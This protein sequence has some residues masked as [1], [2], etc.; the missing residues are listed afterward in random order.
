MTAFRHSL[1][2]YHAL[3]QLTLLGIIIG[4]FAGL[5][6]IAF[7]W[8]IEFSLSIFLPTHNENFESLSLLSRFL[9][10][11]IGAFII[12]LC[13]H[14]I[15]KHFHHVSIGHVLERL[16]NFQGRMPFG[17][18]LV[19]FF[20]GIL[21][22][23]TGQSV[24][25]EGPAVHI[26]ASIA[27][28]LGQWFRLPSNS[29][30][31]LIGCGVAAAIAASFNTPVAGVIFAMEVILMRYSI[32]GFIPIMM[33]SSCGAL[34]TR[35]TF[36]EENWFALTSLPVNSLSELPYWIMCGVVIALFASFYIMSQM[37]FRGLTHWPLP[38]RILLAGF[39]TASIGLLFPQI[40]GLGY[41]TITLALQNHFTV[42]F[43]FGIAIAKIIATSF[44]ISMGIPGGLIGPQLLIG[45]SLGGA[46]GLMGQALLGES[47]TDTRLYVLLGMMAMMGSVLNAPL[48][49]LTA[50]M[51]LTYN[52]N[53]IF[54]GMLV[55]VISCVLTRQI[56]KSE[57]IFLQQLKM[58]GTQLK[59][60]PIQQHLNSIGIRS[61][62]TQ[63]FIICEPNIRL[64]IIKHLLANN[65]IWIIIQREEPL[66]LAA[67]DLA[68]HCKEFEEDNATDD[69]EIDLLEIPAKRYDLIAL[70]E[71][72]N[73]WEAKMLLDENPDSA[74]RVIPQTN[75]Q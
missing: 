26:G 68:N 39:V 2:H 49:A 14:F 13:L 35:A 22:L 50:I 59:N 25:R 3:P 47:I 21:S 75:K 70:H 52:P 65:P 28:L 69:I 57:G 16:H 32:N 41:D 42:T 38:L 27:S 30:Q 17:N 11:I 8:I 46:L 45:A 15:P 62:M 40:L 6:I 44:S 9:L 48:A 54:P 60:S 72:A 56:T 33:A 74:L 71:L 61:V 23:V 1:A 37:R 12:A 51:E 43:L 73:L 36:G 4:L 24:G 29:L 20:G 66:L 18:L 64:S 58:S 31:T 7:R 34:I 63:G 10:P 67:S 5:L 55:I 19:Q 53:I